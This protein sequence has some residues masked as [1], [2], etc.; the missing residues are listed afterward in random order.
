MPVAKLKVH[1][2]FVELCFKTVFIMNGK[3]IVNYYE[4]CFY[5]FV[6]KTFLMHWAHEMLIWNG[7]VKVGTYLQ[8]SFCQV[9]MANAKYGES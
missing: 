1:I 9:F 2:T 5:E 7:N 3:T 8:L 4:C 6:F